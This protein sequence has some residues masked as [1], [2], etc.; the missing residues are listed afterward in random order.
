MS[1]SISSRFF[2][3]NAQD[4]VQR[5]EAIGGPEAQRLAGEA[6][7]LVVMFRDWGV[8]RPA[9]QAR[10]AGITR[11]FD[12]NRRAMDFLAKNGAPASGPRGPKSAPVASEGPASTSSHPQL[13]RLDD[14]DE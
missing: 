5:L 2:L 1:T 13:P 7:E 14:D 6:R 9:D 12:L 10:V 4:L 8:N 11:L 3:G